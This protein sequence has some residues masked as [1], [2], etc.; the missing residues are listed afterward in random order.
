MQERLSNL[1]MLWQSNSI[2][3]LSMTDIESV[4]PGVW[5]ST[6][7]CWWPLAGGWLRL[8]ST[9][10]STA[11]G[12]ALQT[13]TLWGMRPARPDIGRFGAQNL[14]CTCGSIY[15]STSCGQ[16]CRTPD[17]IGATAERILLEKWN[18]YHRE[19]TGQVWVMRWSKDIYS[20]KEWRWQ[21]CGTTCSPGSDLFLSD[22]SCIKRTQK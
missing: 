10:W 20:E 21:N 4:S 3:A 7:R 13:I 6:T 12:W 5:R 22:P 17:H 14:K 19:H 8:R 1:H 16:H 18:G 11:A 2:R 9:E 15:A